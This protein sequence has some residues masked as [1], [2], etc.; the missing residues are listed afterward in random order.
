MT[1]AGVESR[2]IGL[3]E[4]H[5][6]ATPLGDPIEVEALRSVFHRRDDGP[7]CALGSVKSNL[8]H[9]DTAAGIASLLKAVLAVERAIIPPCLHFRSPNPALRLEDSPSTSPRRP[10]RGA[11]RSAAPGCPRSASAAPTAT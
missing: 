8:G 2:Q 3:I 10:N 11:R 7:A 9:L 1:L 4:A 6:T 5:G